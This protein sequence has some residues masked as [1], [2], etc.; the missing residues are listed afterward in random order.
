LPED[1]IL[2]NPKNRKNATE[3][4]VPKVRYELQGLRRRQLSPF[5][6][7]E[8]FAAIKRKFKK[9]TGKK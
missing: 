9:F 2:A 8:V 1:T 7:D 6:R 3:L 5:I 4:V